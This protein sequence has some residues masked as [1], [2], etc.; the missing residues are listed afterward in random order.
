M[1]NCAKIMHKLQGGPQAVQQRARIQKIMKEKIE[2]RPK[3]EN[4]TKKEDEETEELWRRYAEE[5]SQEEHREMIG[6]A[7]RWKR[8]AVNKKKNEVRAEVSKWVMEAV[9]ENG[10]SKA[11][12]LAA[13]D[14]KMPAEEREEVCKGK[15]GKQTGGGGRAPCKAMGR[16]LEGR[17]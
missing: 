3:P 4:S 12:K 14:K 16:P 8:K 2:K 17:R 1:L 15:D 11:H 5:L 9:E 6:M 7:G 10:A 13:P